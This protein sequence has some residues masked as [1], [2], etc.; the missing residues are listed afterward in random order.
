MQRRL[1]VDVDHVDARASPERRRHGPR[2]F[3][4]NGGE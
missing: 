4:L 2:V 1:A 3:L